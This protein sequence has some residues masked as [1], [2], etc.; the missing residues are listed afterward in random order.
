MPS[1]AVAVLR[2]IAH[3]V[4]LAMQFVAE[5]NYES[6]SEDTRTL[7]A[8]TPALRSFQKRLVASLGS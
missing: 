1:D 2:D 4:E 6:F 5:S 3:H 7:F 8:V